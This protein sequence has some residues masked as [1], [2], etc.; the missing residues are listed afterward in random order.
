MKL[1]M[2]ERNRCSQGVVPHEGTWI[3]IRETYIICCA[4]YVVP[5]EGTWIEIITIYERKNKNTSFPTRER[6]LKLLKTRRLS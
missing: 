4:N 2:A 6:G 5:H 3:E 1:F